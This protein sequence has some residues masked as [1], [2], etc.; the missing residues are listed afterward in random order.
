MC[1][2]YSEIQSNIQRS[3][4]PFIGVEPDYRN[5]KY[6]QFSQP[7]S[8]RTI[9]KQNSSNQ[10]TRESDVPGVR[11]ELPRNHFAPKNTRLII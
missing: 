9:S 6:R 1:Q 4:D 7:Q 10:R 8:P 11:S 3:L 5:R 2:V